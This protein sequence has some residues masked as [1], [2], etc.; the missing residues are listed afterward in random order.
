MIKKKFWTIIYICITSAFMSFAKNVNSADIAPYV[1][2]NNIAQSPIEFSY[3]P[4]GKSYL[5]LSKDG[6][7][8]FQYDT[9][10]GQVIDT[11]INVDATREHTIKNIS[12]FTI[13]PNG[14][15]LLIYNNKTKIY[16]RSFEASYYVFEIKRNILRPLSKK[17]SKQ[18]APLF[19]PDSRMVAFVA[20]NNIHIKKIDYDSEVT[21]TNDGKKNSVI[22]GVPDWTYEEEFMV[23]S[24]MSWSPD[25]LMLCYIKYNEEDV[26]TYKFPLY[27]GICNKN[28]G[29]AMYPDEYSYKYPKAGTSN[30]SVSVHSYDVETRKIKNIDL[31]NSEIEYIP[32]IEFANNSTLIVATLNRQQNKLEL[33]SANPRTLIVKSL[34]VD[35]SNAWIGE[36]CYNNL[37]LYP[38]YFV[39]S[40]AR[41]GYNHLYKYAY[42]GV[43]LAQI[44]KGE[45]D[46]LEYYGNDTEGNHYFQ[47]TK[48][49]A[50]NRVITKI[51]KKGSHIDISPSQGCSFATFSPQMNY[52]MINYSNVLT[53]PIYTIYN[54]LNKEL[55][56]IEKN[57]YVANKYSSLP[58]REFFTMEA[59]GLTLNGYM[60][61]P[62]NFDSSKDY[63][64]IMTLYN[65]P[66]SQV[67]LNKWS[68]D[69]ENYFATQG[70][71]I[72]C[73]DGRGTAGRGQ[74]FQN[75]VYKN[76][77][78]YETIDQL[79][80]ANYV[81]S[82]P[83]V[84]K[85][86]IGI[87]GWSYGGYET[88][89]AISQ[90]NAPYKAA[91]AIAPVTD[92]KFYD[93][94]YTERF[95]Q[96]PQENEEGYVNSSVLNKVNNVNC[97][98]LIMSG[99]ADDN[100]HLSNT[101]EYVSSLIENGKYC[102]LFLFPNMNHSIYDCGSR[103]V[104]YA[105]MLDFFN[106]NLK[107][108]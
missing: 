72:V 26:K 49:G 4:D 90:E 6:K 71:L 20:E 27:G 83:Y 1:F 62:S 18:R 59:N 102:D 85:E 77:G 21:V 103:A 86:R 53:P 57:E 91:V 44:T 60:V 14:T 84:D 104:V 55:R 41:S 88:L 45:Y 28:E 101:M 16:R 70:Y 51:D 3:M 32:K 66:S 73:V 97:Q 54:S 22:N 87:Y 35:N 96:T 107:E 68:I 80:A 31:Q 38:E 105:K 93:T 81:S 61:K 52:Y 9:E 17:Y 19:S 40:S 43:E 108:N 50:I 56:V 7:M 65:G 94:A 74:E 48:S 33:Y 100:V 76:I 92:W 42:T 75:A 8:I 30:S 36:V 79:A 64:V 23:E 37:K 12:G 24:S 58:K 63:P 15:K 5:S 11:I 29:Y 89:M 69:W 13:S 46:V 82:L 10:K 98:L 2:P 78:Y 95:M 99:T 39:I 47:S 25:N 67:V 34:Y 106:R